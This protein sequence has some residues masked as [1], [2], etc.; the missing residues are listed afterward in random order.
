M[1]CCLQC[2]YYIV[3]C[4][5]KIRIFAKEE[6]IGLDNHYHPAGLIICG[7]KWQAT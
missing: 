5:I 7:S 1:S 4:H 6:P 3:K 2:V